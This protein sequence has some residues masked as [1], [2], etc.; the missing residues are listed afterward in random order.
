MNPE[1]TRIGW[2]GTG[3]MGASMAGHL[4]AAGFDL[5]VTTRSKERASGVLEAGARWADTPSDVAAE[6]DIV[7]SIVGD[8]TAAEDLVQESFI[9]VYRNAKDFKTIAKFSTWLYRIASNC[10][11]S[12]TARHMRPWS[13]PFTHMEAM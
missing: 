12:F 10:A 3:V 7:F 9:R 13:K 4:R 6:S 1:T 5:T 2:I 11:S 8:Q